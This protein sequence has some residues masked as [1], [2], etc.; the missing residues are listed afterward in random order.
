MKHYEKRKHVLWFILCLLLC[1]VT[2]ILYFSTKSWPVTLTVSGVVLIM[3]G[4][5]CLLLL[6]ERAYESDMVTRL[7]DLIDTITELRNE[8]IFPENEDTLLSKL[9]SQVIKLTDILKAQKNKIASEKSEIETLISDL[10]HQLKTPTATLSLYGE[11]LANQD[12][13]EDERKQYII[14]LNITIEKL[15]FLIDSLIKMGRLET[16]LIHLNPEQSAITDTVLKAVKSNMAKAKEKQIDITYTI[17]K[18]V[19]L[20]HDR[21]WTA[22]AIY[23]ILEN[24]VK[25]TP[26]NGRINIEVIPYEMFLRI[27]IEDNGPGI[28]EEEQAKIFGRFYRGANTAD[29]EGLG[30]GLYLSR[31]IITRQGGYLKLS[32][33]KSGSKFSVFL[34]M[35]GT[36][37]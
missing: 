6:N 13:T 31:E 19:T 3:T 27:D 29:T 20:R 22:E 18:E 30:I 34:P 23:N 24:A 26:E 33:D 11:L 2:L 10:S 9:Q 16:G 12:I 21:N 1:S 4:V 14:E 7:S 35:A 5:F 37:K 28:P 8:P 36:G 15:V 17:N 25:Y 32:S